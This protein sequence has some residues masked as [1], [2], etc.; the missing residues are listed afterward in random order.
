MG[1]DIYLNEPGGGT[2]IFDEPHHMK[3]GTFVLGGTRQAWLKVT[4]NYSPIL[5]HVMEGGIRSI[6]GKTGHESI[7]ILEGA[8]SLLKDDVS[9]DY[10]EPTE[11]NVKKALQNL[12]MMARMRPDGVWDGD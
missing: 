11:G 7:P 10:W 5:Y 2:I 12:L 3:G 8:I 6:Y 9:D 1:Y 4:Y